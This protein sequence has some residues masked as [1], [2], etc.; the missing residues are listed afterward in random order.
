[1][2]DS[3]STSRLARELAIDS[4]R[5]TNTI[6]FRQQK[7][8]AKERQNAGSDDRNLPSA[9][10]CASRNHQSVSLFNAGKGIGRN[11]SLWVAAGPRTRAS[12]CGSRFYMAQLTAALQRLRAA[13]FQNLSNP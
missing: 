7:Y 9:R 4:F 13:R 1:M 8:P 10:Q 5:R 11:R 6:G 3:T 12:A 2:K